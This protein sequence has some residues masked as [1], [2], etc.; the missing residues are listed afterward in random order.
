MH[1]Y[2]TD[3]KL[4]DGYLH[5]SMLDD[6]NNGFSV[7]IDKPD[8]KTIDSGIAS[9]MDMVTCGARHDLMMKAVKLCLN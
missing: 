6:S 3:A 1:K 2:T 9:L 4:V 5:L 7:V 8:P